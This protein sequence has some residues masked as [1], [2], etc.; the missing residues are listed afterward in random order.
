[1]FIEDTVLIWLHSCKMNFETQP[2]ESLK[3][4]VLKEHS[5]PH[6]LSLTRGEVRNVLLKQLRN[7]IYEIVMTT[8]HYYSH[9]L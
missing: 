5:V 4:I 1:M 8:C 7:N 9:V 3:T 6:L 2:Q